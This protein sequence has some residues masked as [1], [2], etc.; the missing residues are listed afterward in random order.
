MS[1]NIVFCAD[2]T[3]NG[4]AEPDSDDKS[5]CA[6][7][8]FKLFLNLAGVDTPGTFL[9]EKEQER[10][11]SVNGGTLQQVAKY[12]C[13]VG[14]SDNFLVK[15]M[16]GALGAGLIARIVRGYTFVSR[17]YVAGDK[18]FLIGFSR[19]A[20]T[21]RALA[22]LIAAKGLLDATKLDLSIKEAAYRWGA[23]VWYQYRR[24]ALQA[25][26]G[27]LGQLENRVVDLPGFLD[28]PPPSD[29]L[30]S[31]PIPIEAVGVWDTVGSLGIPDYNLGTP[32]DNEDKV[33]VDVFQF[34]DSK[35][36][37]VVNHGFHAIAVD[38]Q[39]RDFTPTLWEPDPTRV[40]QVLFPGA[41]KDVGGGYPTTGNESGL[42]DRT[43]QWMTDQLKGLGVKFA[44]EQTIVP[45]PDATGV[46]HQPWLAPPFDRL[47][48]GP[49]TFTRESNLALA[50]FVID[51]MNARPV[52]AG[53]S[54]EPARYAPG[55]LHAYLAGNAAAPG[56]TVET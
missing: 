3:W 4:P 10:T 26:A 15:A 41:H 16:G 40:I 31:P 2:G 43:L 8:V 1:K 39:R 5:A 47:P 46:A 33:P 28:K 42:S 20:Y 9:L 21:A 22:G 11:L 48:T 19:G 29:Q 56:V 44:E 27:L 34:A 54:L 37:K 51:R 35:L 38:E 36:S 53:P 23:A 55:N 49:R 30:V 12:L 7:N 14:D 32:H 18:I 50:Q 52:Q 25:N 13:G 6:T 17:K 24:A 45:K